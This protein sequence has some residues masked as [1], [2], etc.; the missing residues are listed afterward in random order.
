VAFSLRT[1]PLFLGAVA[2]LFVAMRKGPIISKTATP[3]GV[4]IRTSSAELADQ[5]RRQALLS[6]WK[7]ADVAPEPV[8]VK[9][10]EFF[11]LTSVSPNASAIIEA[12]SL[13]PRE[14]LEEFRGASSD[15]QVLALFEIADRPGGAERLLTI[16]NDL[17]DTSVAN[18]IRGF[19]AV[20]G[21]AKARGQ[22]WGD[23]VSATAANTFHNC[24]RDAEKLFQRASAQ[25]PRNVACRIGL[26]SI[27]RG[28]DVPMAERKL[29]YEEV[30]R[31]E[32]DSFTA[33][34]QHLQNIAPK[35]SG[36][37]DEMLA[38][39]RDLLDRCGPGHSLAGV[40]AMA[41]LESAIGN[42]TGAA[43]KL[44]QQQTA[45]RRQIV[46]SLALALSTQP[47]SAPLL[48]A[49]NMATA[50]AWVHQ[51]QILVDKGFAALNGRLTAMPWSY[52]PEG[53]R[54]ATSKPQTV[55]ISSLS[56]E[57]R[58]SQ[59][60]SQRLPAGRARL[61]TGIGALAP[62]AFVV[63][64]VFAAIKRSQSRY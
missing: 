44:A 41:Q 8:H 38:F 9:T 17:G 55:D 48:A 16:A 24:L 19:V 51:E 21:G 54:P 42:G 57:A 62:V 35:W 12:I 10:D 13:G 52:F 60:W 46:E 50:S 18:T 37:N 49:V 64:R 58:N 32:P 22:G 33:A 40:A 11:K 53:P 59:N 25:D 31:L 34:A 2:L 45:I 3:E 20:D 61:R 7:S 14:L 29:R 15:D 30:T 23:T 56:R 5:L 36:N 47:T 43:A 28:L 63:L 27:A 26:V 6:S 1:I 4:L 39:G